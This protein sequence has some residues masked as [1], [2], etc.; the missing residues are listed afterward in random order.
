M[1]LIKNLENLLT[2][3]KSEVSNETLENAQFIVEVGALTVGTDGSGVV[4]VENKNFPT[5]FTKSAVD[6]IITADFSDANGNK[7]MPIVYKK[8][9]WYINKI[10]SLEHT[11]SLLNK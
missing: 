2:S 4:I 5:Q 3:Y 10:K 8:N 7:I 11:I 9:E 6:K 1:K